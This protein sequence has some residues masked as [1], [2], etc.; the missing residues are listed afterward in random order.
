M[1]TTNS[2]TSSTNR[3]SELL[4]YDNEREISRN[5]NPLEWWCLK[6]KYP[7]LSQLAYKFLCIT[8]TSAPSERMFSA[9]LHLTSDRRARLKP[10]NADI[11]LFLNKN[12]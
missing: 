11:L 2:T 10:E 8:G 9:T 1:I 4:M 5:D 7:I 12:G 6:I 3:D